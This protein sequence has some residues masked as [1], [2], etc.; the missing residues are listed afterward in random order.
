[1]DKDRIKGVGKEVAGTVKE[2]AGKATG[3]TVL[4]AKGA[5]EKAV[6]TAQNAA[7][8]VRH[9]VRDTVKK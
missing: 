7:G 9:S 5:T 1:M 3:D 6:G 4:Q 8:G 2:A